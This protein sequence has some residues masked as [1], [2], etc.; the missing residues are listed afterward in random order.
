MLTRIMSGP[1][2][3]ISG[4]HQYSPGFS[5]PVGFPVGLP[6]VWNDGLSIACEAVRSA[7]EITRVVRSF[8]AKFEGEVL[9]H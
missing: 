1:W 8:M 3:E 2:G 6:F 4:C 9:L 7:T 5:R